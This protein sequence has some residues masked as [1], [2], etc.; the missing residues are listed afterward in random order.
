M[1]EDREEEE[2][3]EDKWSPGSWFITATSEQRE[4]G[5][6]RRRGVKIWG[7]RGRGERERETRG[8]D[9]EGGE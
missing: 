7:G 6:M 4:R 1:E 3:E 8:R 5:E 2:V 9:R